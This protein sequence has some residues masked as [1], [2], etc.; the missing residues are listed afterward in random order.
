MRSQLGSELNTLT[1][2]LLLGCLL[3]CCIRGIGHWRNQMP[4]ES[5]RK[6]KS[7]KATCKTLPTFPEPN[8][9]G[10][11]LDLAEYETQLSMIRT[12]PTANCLT[13]FLS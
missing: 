2:K 1:F 12:F 6:E 4:L 7:A 8:R 9:E 11:H 10:W 13:N 5:A 3:C